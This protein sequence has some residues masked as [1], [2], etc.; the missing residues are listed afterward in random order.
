MKKRVTILDFLKLCD[1]C[2]TECVVY[3]TADPDGE[4]PLYEG[5]TFNMPWYVSLYELD[6]SLNK[7]V[8][9]AGGPVEFRQSLGA[10][11]NNRSGFIFL[12]KEEA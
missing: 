11:H 4:D 6:T 5:S 8:Y 3:S 10:E 12:V 2:G 7:A 1:C 9:D